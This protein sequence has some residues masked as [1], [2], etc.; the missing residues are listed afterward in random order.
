MMLKIKFVQLDYNHSNTI[1]SRIGGE[2]DGEKRINQ[3]GRELNK[4][5]NIANR[6]W[7]DNNRLYIATFIQIRVNA[8][9]LHSSTFS[10]PDTDNLYLYS[11]NDAFSKK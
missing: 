8:E 1:T 6:A 7:K 5:Y 10:L 9:C 3:Y 4:W 2:G 11:V